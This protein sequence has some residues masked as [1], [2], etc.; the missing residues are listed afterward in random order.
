[1]YTHSSY[2]KQGFAKQVLNALETWARELGYTSLC[3]ETGHNQPEALALYQK[4]GYKPIENYE[5]YI[6]IANSL[7]FEKML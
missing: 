5:P 6:G 4:C 3:L 7:C 2:R 1:M